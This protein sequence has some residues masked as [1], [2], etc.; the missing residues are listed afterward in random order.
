MGHFTTSQGEFTPWF[1]DRPPR[2]FSIASA[3]PW[4]QDLRDNQFRQR[5]ESQGS[6]IAGHQEQGS[7]GQSRPPRQL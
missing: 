3:P 5:S 4:F 2:P 7:A 1:F 6:Q